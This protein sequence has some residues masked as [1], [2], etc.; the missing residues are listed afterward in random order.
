MRLVSKEFDNMVCQALFRVVVVPF[1]P[2]IYGIASD[3]ENALAHS[4]VML[5]DQGMRVF[6]GYVITNCQA[7]SW[8]N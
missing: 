4:S 3:T 6:Q 5:Q 8:S 2:E 7:I 1:R